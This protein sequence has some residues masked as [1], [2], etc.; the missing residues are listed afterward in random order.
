MDI[1][2]NQKASYLSYLLKST[3]LPTVHA[4]LHSPRT[5][6]RESLCWISAAS[7]VQSDSHEGKL[8]K[9]A[10]TQETG[11]RG[12]LLAWILEWLLMN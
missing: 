4:S 11:A 3:R 1:D 6:E 5:V 12:G 10:K 9:A 8:G 7:N 2:R